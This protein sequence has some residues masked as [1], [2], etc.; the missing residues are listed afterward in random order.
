MT[1]GHKLVYVN[2]HCVGDAHDHVEIR[3]G[4]R[5]LPGF[6]KNLNVPAGIGEG[7]RFFVRIGGRQDNVCECGGLRQEHFL[8]HR[9]GVLE[10]C[11]I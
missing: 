2:A 9:E 10:D 8:H 11:G 7:S 3:F 1:K 5:N 6:F 4:G